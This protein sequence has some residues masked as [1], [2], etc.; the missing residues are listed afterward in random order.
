M[1][2]IL[3]PGK[4]RYFNIVNGIRVEVA[5]ADKAAP[6]TETKTDAI[7]NVLHQAEA[8]VSAAG[9]IPATPVITQ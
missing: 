8:L 1:V 4:S 5:E 9:N 2:T 7:L 6:V 3:E